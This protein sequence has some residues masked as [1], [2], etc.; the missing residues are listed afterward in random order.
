MKPKHQR[1]ILLF[2]VLMGLSLSIGLMLIAFQE[3]IVFFYTPSD[4]FQKTISPHHRIRIGGLVEANSLNQIGEKVRFRITDQK[5]ALT[6]TYM[7][8]LPDLFREG[9]GVVVEGHLLDSGNFQAL[10]VLAKHDEKYMPKD[11]ADRLKQTGLWH[12]VR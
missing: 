5:K 8:I 11:V 1:L 9:Q 12:D 2:S 3:T 10:L 6:I 4:L 7:G